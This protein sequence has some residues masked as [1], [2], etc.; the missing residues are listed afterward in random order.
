MVKACWSINPA[1]SMEQKRNSA[2]KLK[3]VKHT[4]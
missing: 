1:P 3:H 2:I 4:I